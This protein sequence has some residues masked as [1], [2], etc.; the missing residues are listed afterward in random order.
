MEEFYTRVLPGMLIAAGLMVVSFIF[1]YGL[2]QLIYDFKDL[3]L[4]HM[5]KED[6]QKYKESRLS[7]KADA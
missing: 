7:E 4:I 5:S 3:K 2:G 6:Y 1:L